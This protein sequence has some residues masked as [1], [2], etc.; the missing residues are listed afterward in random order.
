M[1]RLIVPDDLD[2]ARVDVALVS[3]V[4]GLSRRRAREAIARGSVKIDGRV[5]AKGD[6]VRAGEEIAYSLAELKDPTFSPEP[7]PEAPLQVI[8]ERG[9]LVV[10]DKPA[11]QPTAPLRQGERGTL[12]GA[13]VARYPEMIGV[14][15]SPREPGIIHRLDIGTSGVVVAARSAA[16][17]E[18][19]RDLLAAESLE[20]TYWVACEAEGLSDHGTVALALANHPSDKRK[21][22]ACTHESDVVKLGARSATTRFE[23]EER[24]GR[25]AL[26]RVRADRALR[27]QIR[28]H[29]AALGHPLI[30]DALYGGPAQEGMVGHALHA[31]RIALAAEDAGVAPFVAE[32]PLGDRWDTWLAAAP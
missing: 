15:Y 25:F 10:V 23:V 19:L 27:H 21:M 1:D 26:V 28:V 5:R 4:P 17:F 32:S 22:V 24:R 14:G 13:L 31:G 29:F 6:V 18:A 30:G 7:E 11:G 3:L 2:G 16:A 20:K 8:L 12:V 9:D